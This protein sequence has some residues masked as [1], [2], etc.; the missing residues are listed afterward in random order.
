MTIRSSTLKVGQRVP[1]LVKGKWL[2]GAANKVCTKPH[3]SVIRLSDGRLLR[4]TRWAINV[5]NA[6]SP[7]VGTSL[8]PPRPL[9]IRVPF[10]THANQP[11]LGQSNGTPAAVV[12]STIAGTSRRPTVVINGSSSTPVGPSS[13]LLLAVHQESASV[14]S[15]EAPYHPIRE[16]SALRS[17]RLFIPRVSVRDSSF[18]AAFS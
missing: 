15:K 3:C 10:V 13:V 14:C 7:A 8:G 4:R 2:L 1:A 17:T 9:F 18:G 5:D 12:H 16:F 6:T 11:F